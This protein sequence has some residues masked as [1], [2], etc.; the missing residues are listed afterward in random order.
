MK[1]DKI[2]TITYALF[3][4]GF[5]STVVPL[6][7]AEDNPCMAMD[8]EGNNAY[9]AWQEETGEIRLNKSG[10]R[11]ISFGSDIS[12]SE[13]ITG[14]NK[15]PSIAVDNTGNLYVIWENQKP[16]GNIDLYFG[17]M[18]N[19]SQK[20]TSAAIPIDTHLGALSRQVQPSL[21]VSAGGTVVIAWV[22]QNGNDGVYYARSSDSGNSFWQITSGQIVRVDGLTAVLPEYPRIKIDAGGQNKY[23]A[24]SAEKDGRKRV[25]FNKL[26][27][28][29]NRVY[30]NDI[31]VNDDANGARVSRPSL[32]LRPQAQEGSNKPNICIAWENEM[33]GDMDIFFDKSVNGDTWGNDI[34]V[35]DDAQTPQPQK[36]PQA[37]IDSNGDIF[38]AWSDFRNGDWDIYF[39]MSIDDGESFK[40]NAIVNDDTG[41][42]TQDKPSLYLSANGKDFCVSWTDY[43]NGDS[44]I[45][46]NRNTII[47]DAGAYT[48]LVD[49][50]SGGVL[51]A[52]ASTQAERTEISVP[53][54]VLETPA[55][56]SITGVQ[57]PP[58]LPGSDILLNKV[59]D[60]GPGGTRF[61]QTVTIKIPYAQSDL[62]SAGITDPNKLTI[63]HYNLKTL[64]WEKVTTSRVDTIN[65][66][67][68]AEVSHF[69]IYGIAGG[70]GG[71]LGGGGGGGSIGGGGGGGSIGGGGGG[72]CF[73][74]TAAYG[75]SDDASVKILRQF[76]DR[77]LLT[78]RLGREFVKFYY[79]HSPPIARY[80]A[81]RDGL[82]RLVRWSLKPAVLMAKICGDKYDNKHSARKK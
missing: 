53:G 71:L 7:A 61:K 14:I 31:Q 54:G 26:N 59:V 39:A 70:V 65:Q 41:S 38:C 2:N 78:N 27:S 62:D 63:Y 17:R 74:A 40:T 10:D 12:V 47:D 45:F 6:R 66:I 20:F 44:E 9:V 21:D 42:A 52:G 79:R 25:F 5:L 13:G 49:N 46:F 72:G 15:N 28:G 29:D 51:K 75:S 76:R 64:L 58:P 56:M 1:R 48:A 81:G 11:G 55:N 23:I 4:L 43:R 24:W 35:N 32:A 33:G 18:P 67:V 30:G 22:N 60:F 36:E 50:S 19:G 68:F 34:Q 57:C 3:V 37:A 77:H 8:K 80:I 73:I 69:S 82:R 16:D